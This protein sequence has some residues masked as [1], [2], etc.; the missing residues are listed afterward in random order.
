MV[1]IAPA[2][3][4]LAFE[5]VKTQRLLDKHWARQVAD[6]HLD[7]RQAG[8]LNTPLGRDLEERLLPPHPSVSAFTV[9]FRSDLVRKTSREAALELRPLNAGY[10]AAFG[11][12]D[13]AHC[14]IICEIRQR[15]PDPES[16]NHQ[17]SPPAGSNPT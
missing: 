16:L 5:A 8:L 17:P 9:N 12:T 11:I 1:S 4:E 3:Q 15:F 6:L 10:R 13:Q 2:L 7:F 14:Q